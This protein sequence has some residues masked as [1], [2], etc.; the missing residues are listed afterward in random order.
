MS[1]FSLTGKGRLSVGARTSALWL[2]LGFYASAVTAFW[3][4]TC[5]KRGHG[6]IAHHGAIP[7]KGR[8]RVPDGEASAVGVD[9]PVATLPVVSRLMADATR[10]Y[11]I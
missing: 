7:G 6:G 5:T 2:A 1:C 9:Q 11:A 4:A 8:I 3:A 10:K